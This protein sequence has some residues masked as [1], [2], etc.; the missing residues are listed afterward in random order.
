MNYLF[1][2]VLT[3]RERKAKNEHLY[4]A[5]KALSDSVNKSMEKR[6]NKRKID[7]N[8]KLKNFVYSPLELRWSYNKFQTH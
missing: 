6:F 3:P 2:Q 5:L 7:N 1:I 4:N 8:P